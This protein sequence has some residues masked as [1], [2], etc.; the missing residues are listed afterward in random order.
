[1]YILLMYEREMSKN[2]YSKT[3]LITNYKKHPKLK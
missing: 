2:D 1:M 3:L